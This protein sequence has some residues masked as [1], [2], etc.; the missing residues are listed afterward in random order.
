MTYLTDTHFHLD[1]YKNY[2]ELYDCINES[3]QYTLCMT[4]SPGIYN[5]CCRILGESKYI[6]FAMGFHPKFKDLA[7]NDFLQFIEMSYRANY[8]GEIGLDFSNSNKNVPKE[9]QLLYFDEI[10]KI[11]SNDNKLMSIHLKRSENYAIEI[12]DKYKPQKALIH[13]FNG[14]RKQLEALI[15]LNCYFSIN[16]N[17]LAKSKE[18]IKLIPKDKIL[19]ESD[20]PFTKVQNKKFYPQLLQS[21]YEQIATETRIDD[22]KNLVYQNFNTVLSL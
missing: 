5:S 9:K 12:L 16:T 3:K 18:L 17:M 14:S 2:K 15:K 6:K 4:N 13:W 7:I 8:F 1:Y 22:F 19:V 11:A 20:G 21:A 10:V